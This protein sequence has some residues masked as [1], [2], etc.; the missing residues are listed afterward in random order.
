M[1]AHLMN[2]QRKPGA[3][4][5]APGEAVFQDGLRRDSTTPP[6]DKLLPLLERVRRTGADRWIAR[7]PS[8]NGDAQSLSVREMPDGLLLLKCWSRDC[9][10]A[11]I[12]EAVGLRLADLFP[13]N[14]DRNAQR[15]P[16]RPGARWFPAD[17]LRGILDAALLV[18]VCAEDVANGKTIPEATRIRLAKAA[19]AI[20]RACEEVSK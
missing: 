15:P 2:A 14:H 19:G 20:W 9:G 7:C 1:N 10:A 8:H 18:L 5:A 6:I 13:A 17:A 3:V 12:V 11:A 16:L 4:A